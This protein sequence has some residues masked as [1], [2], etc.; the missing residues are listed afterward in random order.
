MGK[1]LKVIA[2]S[3]LALGIVAF[4]VSWEGAKADPLGAIWLVLFAAPWTFV[5]PTGGGLG[6]EAKLLIMG[7]FVLVNAGIIYGLGHL[8]TRRKKLS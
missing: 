7:G 8:L 4:L 1:A 6:V 3:Y 2:W 5:L